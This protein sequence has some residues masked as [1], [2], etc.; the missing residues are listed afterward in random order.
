MNMERFTPRPRVGEKLGR[1]R[2]PDFDEP[3]IAVHNHPNGQTFSVGDIQRV[4]ERP[5][6]QVCTMEK[7]SVFSLEPLKAMIDEL[8]EQHPDYVQDGDIHLQ[9]VE[10]FFERAKQYGLHLYTSSD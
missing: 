4:L 6:C 9:L 2:L 8:K 10:T 7:A 1:I 5:N 3:Y